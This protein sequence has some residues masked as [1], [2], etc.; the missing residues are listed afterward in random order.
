[1]HTK[2]LWIQSVIWLKVSMF[3]DVQSLPRVLLC[4]YS[5]CYLCVLPADFS[6]PQSSIS[7]SEFIHTGTICVRG[8]ALM[9]LWWFHCGR[10]NGDL[11]G[12]WS[13]VKL[14]SFSSFIFFDF[15]SSFSSILDDW[16][17]ICSLKTVRPYVIIFRECQDKKFG[18]N[19]TERKASCQRDLLF[20]C[21][22]TWKYN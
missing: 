5:L 2:W 15:W 18:A 22:L 13:A 7:S 12:S 3:I 10:R 9:C 19:F 11:G 14:M 4:Y 17:Y 20:K 21:L 8:K 16:G 6:A 1:M